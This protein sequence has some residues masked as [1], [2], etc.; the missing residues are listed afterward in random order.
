MSEL[1]A[2]F[3]V[4]HADADAPVLRDVRTG[5]V[6]TLAAQPSADDGGPVAEGEVLEAT[7]TP[8]PPLE[9]AYEVTGVSGRRDLVVE[10]SPEP[11]TRLAEDIAADQPVG[12]VT[13]RERAGEGEVHVLSVPPAETDAA[14]ADVLDDE[15]T[16][17][18][19]ARLG[20][21]RVEVRAADGVVSVRY[22]P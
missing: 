5:Q 1:E 9:V 16:L 14:V 20:V 19:A 3:L 12:E 4:T 13:T 17:A 2:T 18:R 21:G 8:E 10:A 6:C 15:E 7:L 11:P 22:L